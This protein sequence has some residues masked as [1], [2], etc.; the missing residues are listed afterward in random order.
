MNIL[1][2]HTAMQIKHYKCLTNVVRKHV[3]KDCQFIKTIYSIYLH[4]KSF[5]QYTA[6]K[7]IFFTI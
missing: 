6:K 7:L 2:Q 3:I 1:R 5:R 4:Y